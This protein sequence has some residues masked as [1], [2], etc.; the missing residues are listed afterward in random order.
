LLSYSG[1]KMMQLR[2]ILKVPTPEAGPH[3]KIEVVYG[4]HQVV[5]RHPDSDNSFLKFGKQLLFRFCLLLFR[6]CE[7][8]MSSAWTTSS[9][10]SISC[11]AGLGLASLLIHRS[12]VHGQNSTWW[13]NAVSAIMC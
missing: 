3:T 8:A 11:A 12:I 13:S 2:I 4:H 6:F 9:W 10:A 1:L 5:Q 7:I